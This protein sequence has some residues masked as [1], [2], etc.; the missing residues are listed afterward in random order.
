M[1]RGDFRSR[2]HGSPSS[3]NDSEFASGHEGGH[4]DYQDVFVSDR[5]AAL[6]RYD[7]HHAAGHASSSAALAIPQGRSEKRAILTQLAD[8][9]D[10]PDGDVV[11]ALAGA[12]A[13]YA[14]ASS[15]IRR[16]ISGT[17]LA[18]QKEYQRPAGKA[19]FEVRFDFVGVEVNEDEINAN[20]QGGAKSE[21]L[22]SHEQKLLLA[23]VTGGYLD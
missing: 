20:L 18:S 10:G 11:P 22:R 12:A 8:L 17:V 3:T 14:Y 23:L 5:Q 15:L 1:T 21:A 9:L 16:Q 4:T 2:F 13:V 7:E 19:P 6:R